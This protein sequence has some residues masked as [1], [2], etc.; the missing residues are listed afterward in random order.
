[1]MDSKAWDE[2]YAAAELVWSA[3]PNQF[4]EEIGRGLAPGRMLDLAAGEGRNAVWFAE[5]GWEATAVDYSGV[6]LAKASETAA[7]RGVEIATV[8]ADLV[9]YEPEAAAYDLVLI[10]YLH[11]APDERTLVLRRAAAAVAPGGRL[12]VIGHDATNVEHGYGGPTDPSVLTSPGEIVAELGEDFV[13]S[14]S[15]IVD[16]E[17]ETD[18]GIRVAKDTLVLARRDPNG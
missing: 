17:V 6:A 9:E 2:R 1:M 14:R 13:I 8:V 4:V 3:G 7:R 15:E 5:N 12:L 11:I 18:D 10:A 16:R